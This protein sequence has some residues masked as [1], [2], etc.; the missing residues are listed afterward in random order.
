MRSFAMAVVVLA[1]SAPGHA[2]DKGYS[3][4]AAKTKALV[5]ANFKDPEGSRFRNL[6]VYRDNEG[7]LAL[8]GEVNMKNGYGAFVGYRPFYASATNVTF[9]EDGEDSLFDTLRQG[10][11]HKK[12]ADTR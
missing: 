8:C 3:A 9:R 7:K 11:C 12:V 5:T 6:A 4:F 1:L 10:Y 2:Q